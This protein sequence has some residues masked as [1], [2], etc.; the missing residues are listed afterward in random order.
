MPTTRRFE[1]GGRKQCGASV[2]TTALQ[3]DR[4]GGRGGGV[5]KSESRS[6]PGLGRIGGGVDGDWGWVGEA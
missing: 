6:P 5:G 3:E 4:G 2:C 1:S